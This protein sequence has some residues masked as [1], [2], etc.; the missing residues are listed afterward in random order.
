MTAGVVVDPAVRADLD[1]WVAMRHALWPSGSEAKH[2]AEAEAM[3]TTGDGLA[4]C[5]IARRDGG[6]CGFA[7]VSLRHDYV[8][9]CETS[10]VAFLEGI[11]V[12]APAR[13]QGVARAL[14]MAAE[15]WA[16]AHGCTEFASDAAIENVAS[17]AMHKALGF[18]ETRRVVYFRKV[19]AKP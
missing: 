3:L 2:R 6:P 1:I 17:A 16:A 12:M 9:G 7:E 4:A 14:V 15:A 18:E 10:P 11:Y 13:G 5:L 19:L 8:N